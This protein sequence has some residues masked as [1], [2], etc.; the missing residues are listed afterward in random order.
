N[1][2]GEEKM[3][4]ESR[5]TENQRRDFL[6]F[7]GNANAFRILT[8]PFNEDRSSFRLTYTTLASIV[9]YPTDSLN[10]F[11]K[12]RLIT[13]KSGFFDSERPAYEMVAAELGI[14]VIE[15]GKHVYA[16]HPFVYLV[17]AADDICYRIVDFEDAHRLNI[18]S[19]EEIQS[20]F[21]SFFDN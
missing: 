1:L 10:G 4:F 16:R 17:E 20:L 7:E 21:L 19:V 3:I 6:F 5:L 9:K 13:K 12:S 2:Q 18:I 14:P 11:N 15:R 8:H